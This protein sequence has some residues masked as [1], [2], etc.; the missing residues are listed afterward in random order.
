M[1]VFALNEH[2]LIFPKADLADESGLLAIGGKLDVD[3]VL[4]AYSCGI[5]PW[6]NENDPIMW[7]SPN[8][9]SVIVPGNLKIRKSMKSYFRSGRFHLKIDKDFEQ[10]IDNCQNI[11]R[12]GQ[13]GTWITQDMKDVYIE[14]HNLGFAHSF[15]TWEEGKLVG[16]LYGISLGKIFF[17]ESMFSSVSNAS[18]Y[19]LLSLSMIL[20]LNNFRLLDCQIPNPH[21]DNMG[22]VE[23][24]RD[25]YLAL[26]KQ[27]NKD[28]TIVGN[29]GNDLLK[30]DFKI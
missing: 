18:K 12:R 21:L 17:G 9:R 30:T 8:P 25:D 5:F 3:W 10:V 14:L 16:G 29:W 19:A 26:I 15:E 27:N 6:F 20:E 2:R 13:D 7:W 4:E 22:C 11:A 23:M 28:D 1:A 24:S